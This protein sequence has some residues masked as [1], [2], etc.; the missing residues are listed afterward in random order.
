[1][2]I[3][4]MLLVIATLMATGAATPTDPSADRKRVDAE[5]AQAGALLE[6]ASTEARQA[7][8]RLAE[9]NEALSGAQL[10]AAQARGAVAAAE[11][12]VVTTRRRADEARTGWEDARR[13]YDGAASH[14]REGR[15]DL[16]R[17]AAVVHQGGEI[18]A[19][20]AL[21]DS[22]DPG[23]LAVRMGYT[24][25]VAEAKQASVDELVGARRDAKEA[26]NQ[27][28]LAKNAADKALAEAEAAKAEAEAVRGEAE[29]V[30]HELAN[31]VVQQQEAASAAEAYRAEVMGRYEELKRESERIGEELL[32][33]GSPGP[34][35][36]P[37]S[38]LLMP[39]RGW[40]SSDFGMRF[41]PYYSV[42]QLHAGVDIA[43]GGGEPIYAAAD[44]QV[45]SAGW[46]GGYGNYTCLSH[47]TY[48]G[49]SL[50][51]CYAHQSRIL[52]DRG[53]RVSRGQMIGRVG[54]TGAST[55]NHL[56]FEV[57]LDGEPVQP[58]NW[59]P[60]CLC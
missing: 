28:T 54:T 55:G 52:V 30:Q 12:L 5:L 8:G 25:R 24:R 59:L 16:G 22:G 51:T 37:G 49:Q 1:M 6:S 14:V 48:D 35:L 15:E 23:E 53:Q 19:F 11:N 33:A 18:A 7:V 31:V 50:S 20:N 39:V 4:S 36:R 40:K 32:A 41:D 29:S 3:G 47:G 13:R 58:E 2:R 43:A 21:I 56:H 45:A 38:R 44:G 42:W 27:A 60:S 17:Y 10:R 34:V 26:D 9:V 57:R 46:R